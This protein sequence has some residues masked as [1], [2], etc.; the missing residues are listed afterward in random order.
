MTTRL[1]EALTLFND[2]FDDTPPYTRIAFTL[3]TEFDDSRWSGATH[4]VNGKKEDTRARILEITRRGADYVVDLTGSP[5]MLGLAVEALA[6]TGTAALIGA[7]PHGTQA[8][9]DMAS[10]LNGRVIRGV[11]Q[12]DAVPQVFIPKLIALH[13]A[14]KF[15]FDR[16]VQYYDF[17]DVERAFEDSKQGRTIKPVLRIAKS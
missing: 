16:L 2:S 6:P 13:R 1:E 4:V 15:P 11:L 3:D 12:G 14:G 8:S 9:I 5:K 10:L 7:A 17:E